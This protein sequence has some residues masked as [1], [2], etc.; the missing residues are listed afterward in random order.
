MLWNNVDVTI[1]RH[2]DGNAK[3]VQ[4]S[5]P[6]TPQELTPEWAEILYYAKFPQQFV[7]ELQWLT[8]KHINN[9]LCDYLP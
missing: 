1:Y 3:M 5:V 7:N 6:P 4:H 8:V 2:N 9:I